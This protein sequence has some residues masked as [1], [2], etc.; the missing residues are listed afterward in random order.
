M[1]VTNIQGSVSAACNVKVTDDNYNTPTDVINQPV[2]QAVSFGTGAGQVNAFFTE[3]F[4]IAASATQTLVLDN[5]SL[6][7]IYGN[8]NSFATIKYI[9]IQHK[10]DSAASGITIGGTFMASNYQDG[11]ANFTA[12]KTPGEFFNDAEMDVG[13]TVGAGETITLLNNDG[14]NSA[15][16]SIELL[17]TV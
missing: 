5:A 15:I 11:A 12:T 4:T 13:L 17:G 6:V 16:V 14:V 8:T 7:D 9:R 10:F 3:E 1:A 2:N